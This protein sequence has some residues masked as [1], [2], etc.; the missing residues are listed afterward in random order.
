ME[1]DFS[2]DQDGS[3]GDRFETV[4]RLAIEVL[5]QR[6]ITVA[7]GDNDARG[8]DHL[9][10]RDGYEYWLYNVQKKCALLQPHEWAHAV[11][12]HFD[13]ILQGRNAAPVT[14]LSDNDLQRQIRTRLNP[15][16]PPEKMTS[17]YARPAFDGLVVELNRD[18]PTSVQTIVDQQLDGHDVDLLF[19]I[20]Q[21]NTDA[22]PMDI[23]RMDHGVVVLMGDSFFIAS[24][25]LNMPALIDTVF[26]GSAPLGVIFSVPQ[27]SLVLLHAV[28]PQV[29]EALQW[30][31]PVTIG[32][33][34]EAAG[35]ISPD[36]Y[37]WHNGRVQRITQR[38][39]DGDATGILIEGPFADA[40]DRVAAQAQG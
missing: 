4:R 36:T 7:P 28:G 33:A 34:S 38:N 26:G 19:Q 10:D 31:V 5:A 35:P 14:M 9:V 13:H 20:G 23:E 37:Y 27:R 24:K 22:E 1:S 15:P 39:V 8:D 32:Q 30:I 17:T 21:R 29:M 40:I 16:I 25:V 11:H 3:T 6:G 18:L 12:E 2:D